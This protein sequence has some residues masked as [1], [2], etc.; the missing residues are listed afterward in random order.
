MASLMNHHVSVEST[1]VFCFFFMFGSFVVVL[2][3]VS[4]FT[5]Q[6]LQINIPPLSGKL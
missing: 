6:L 1:V 5:S 3:G 2:P 4:R